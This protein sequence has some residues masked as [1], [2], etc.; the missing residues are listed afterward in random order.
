MGTAKEYYGLLLRQAS[1]TKPKQVPFVDFRSP[2]NY[3]AVRETE[4]EHLGYHRLKSWRTGQNLYCN[5]TTDLFSEFNPEKDYCSRH[6]GLPH[7]AWS[8]I[9]WAPGA[10]LYETRRSSQKLQTQTNT[11]Q[12]RPPHL[13]GKRPWGVRRDFITSPLWVDKWKCC[14]ALDTFFRADPSSPP[15][16]RIHGQQ[17]QLQNG[18]HAHVVFT[19]V[20]NAL[21]ICDRDLALIM[22]GAR[23]LAKPQQRA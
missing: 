18:T 23:L 6:C 12:I 21:H 1:I 16:G 19:M 14:V 22:L 20:K 3:A 17:R 11:N 10:L 4:R 8:W 13:H 2:S 7:L 5:Q 15:Q 9:A